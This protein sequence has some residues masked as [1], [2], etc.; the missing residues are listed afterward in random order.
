MTDPGLR[1]TPEAH[2]FY[3]HLSPAVK[4]HIKRA[5]REIAGVPFGG[6]ALQGEL[7][8]YWSYRIQRYRVVYRFN[9]AENMLE[10]IHF[11]H[12]S[13]IYERLKA[14]LKQSA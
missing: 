9:E 3:S 1:L 6:K 4:K 8:G 7:S 5:L 10:V 13:H 11:D 2:A 14:M 12:C